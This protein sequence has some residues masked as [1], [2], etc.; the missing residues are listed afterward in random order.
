VV[1]K[2]AL[3]LACA[4]LLAGPFCFAALGDSDSG[5]HVAVGRLVLQGAFPRTNALSWK[6]GDHP[7]YPTSWLFDVLCALFSSPAGLQLI[8]FAFLALTLLALCFACETPWIVPAIALLL[9]PRLV[10]RPH[11][12]SWAVLGGILALSPRGT[13]ARALCIPLVALGGNLHAGAAFAAFVLVLEC[14]EAFWRT[15]RPA[16]LLLAALAGLSLLANPG[17]LFD[18]RYLLHHLLEVNDVVQLREFEPP[19]FLLRPAFFLLLPA[20]LLVAVHRR[21]ERPALLVATMVFAALGLRALRMVSEAQIVWAPTLA[22]GLARIPPRLLAPAGAAAALLAGASLRLDRTALAMRLSPVWDATVLPVRAAR[23]LE[24]NRISGPGFNAFRDG[25]YLEM[26][27]PGSKAFID[28]RVQ[29]Y[30][31]EAWRALQQA[32]QSAPA[33]Q[34][35]LESAG[36]EWAIATRVRERLGGYRLIHGPRWALVYWDDA[37]EVFVR[38]DVVRFA[39]LLQRLE[40]RHFRPFGGSIVGSVEKLQRPELE[41]LVREIERF[42]QTSP[43]DPLA[44]L[45]RCAALTRLGAADR[46]PACDDA[47]ARVPAAATPLLAKV[48]SLQAAP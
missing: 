7:W 20:S 39:E 30:P 45:E 2:I 33:F 9:A 12:A 17:M 5:W 44:L 18:A 27:R 43:G 23:F 19:S 10:P 26:A 31:T 24:E 42:G 25:G 36:C 34:A 28:A 15:R 47:A 37:S 14:V 41:Q 35:W 38:R 3:P 6:W 22:W 48:R 1:R 16:E 13:L 32:E 8:T 46:G 40:Y 21:R 11:V 4:L 29:A